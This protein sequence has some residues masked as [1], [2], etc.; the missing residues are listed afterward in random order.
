MPLRQLLFFFNDTATTEIYTLSLHDALP[1]SAGCRGWW[2]PWGE[3]PWSRARGCRGAPCCRPERRLR[4]RRAGARPCS[5]G[6]GSRPRALENE[7][8]EEPDADRR[9][10]FGLVRPLGVGVR[11]A[12]DV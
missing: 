6:R 5:R 4:P 1:I 11:G 10:A 8:G 12:G 7:L 2:C 9:R 3:A